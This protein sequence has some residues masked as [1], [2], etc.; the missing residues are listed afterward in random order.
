M[1]SGN[2]LDQFAYGLL[3]ESGVSFT[4]TMNVVPRS[5]DRTY[6][7]AGYSANLP[8]NPGSCK[9]AFSWEK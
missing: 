7:I 5:C 1:V 2:E 4:S 8:S 9:L 3:V 6:N